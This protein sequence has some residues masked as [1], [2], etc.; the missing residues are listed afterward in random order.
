[1]LLRKTEG[2]GL[3]REV[4]FYQTTGR[5]L[6]G[7]CYVSLCPGGRAWLFSVLIFEE[8]RGLGE[9]QHM[10]SDVIKEALG[11]SEIH[12]LFL[13]VARENLVAQHIYRKAGFRDVPH[14]SG[15]MVLDLDELRAQK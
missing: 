14:Y 2:T 5:V 10:L 7:R 3:D 6:T 8:Y 1:M 12:R 4:Y 11:L 13:D 15:R 9:A